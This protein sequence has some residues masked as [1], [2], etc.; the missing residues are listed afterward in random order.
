VPNL[1]SNFNDEQHALQ[2]AHFEPSQAT[3]GGRIATARALETMAIAADMKAR[4]ISEVAAWIRQ[5]KP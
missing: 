3:A 2:L 5:H 1:M 4:V